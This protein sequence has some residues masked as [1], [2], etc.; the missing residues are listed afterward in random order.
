MAITKVRVKI[1]GTW[2]NLTKNSSTG[3][4]TG[5]ITA[6]STT[7]FNLSG[8][9]YPVT[10]EATNDAGTVK[11]WEASDSTWGSMLQLVV[12][13]TIKPTITI[14]S[15]SNGAYITNNK[16]AITFKVT[17]EAGGSGVK[18]SEVKLKID[19]TT[20]SYN[21]SG[22]SYEAITNGYQFVYTPQTALAD[23]KHTIT[24]NASDNDGN[25]AT[26]ATATITVDT[27]PP[28]LS[29]STPAAGLITN[30]PSVNVSGVTNDTTS[31]PVTVKIT[32]NGAN[33]GNISVGSDGS[34][35]KAVTL[36]EGTNTI[37]VTATDAAGKTSSITRSVKL[38]TTIPAISSM[39]LAP[40][41]ANTS[42]SVTITI[43]VS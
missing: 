8:G 41:P 31:S 28:T 27:V 40:N 37:V 18:L 30:N 10:V 16:Q 15:P 23:G 11:T 19:S 26:A 14:V 32:L 35:S 3:K 13:E 6:P 42:A 1:N 39:T 17:D 25:A 43:E 12:K 2:T 34:F 4:W 20:Y 33:Q 21:S 22:M 38:D 24:V 9:Y 29:V 5:N 36:A 7:S